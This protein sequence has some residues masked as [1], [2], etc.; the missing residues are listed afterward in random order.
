M[1]LLQQKNT[2]KIEKFI[3]KKQVHMIQQ[4]KI[5]SILI[6]IKT[7]LLIIINAK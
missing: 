3:R 6:N 5:N 2:D 4:T 7:V 1:F